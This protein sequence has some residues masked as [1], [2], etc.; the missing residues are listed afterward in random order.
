VAS[1]M[2]VMIM[3]RTGVQSRFGVYSRELGWLLAQG[4]RAKVKLVCSTDRGLLQLGL[5]V[6]HLDRSGLFGGGGGG[7]QVNR[8]LGVRRAARDERHERRTGV[9]VRRRLKANGVLQSDGW[10][11]CATAGDDGSR[12]DRP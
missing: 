1:G 10:L 2:P 3:Q 8:G 11:N 6:G 12:F 7:R 4:I 5:L 9:S